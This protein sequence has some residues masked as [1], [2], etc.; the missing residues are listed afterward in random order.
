MLCSLVASAS[1]DGEKS[2]LLSRFAQWREQ[3]MMKGV[4]TNYI[5][6]PT[7]AWM[8]RTNALASNINIDEQ[9][10]GD[11]SFDRLFYNINT[12]LCWKSNL[13]LSYRGLELGYGIDFSKR[14]N[15]DIKLSMYSKGFGGEIH[16]QT[17]N[18]IQGT[19]QLD[20]TGGET[21]FYDDIPMEVSRIVVNG[22][23]VFNKK[24]FSYPAAITKSFI[25]K[26]SAGSAIAGISLLYYDMTIGDC[27]AS[28]VYD[29]AQRI[30]TFVGSAGAGYAYNFVPRNTSWLFH[31]SALPM[32]SFPISKKAYNDLSM[33][34]SHN[35]KPSEHV[36]MPSVVARTS[37]SYSI[38]DRIVLGANCIYNHFWSNPSGDMLLSTY[39]ITSQTFIAFRF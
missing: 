13:S 3:S 35:I 22:Y 30:K 5:C 26:K 6:L 16:Y 8:V 32:L 37:V 31:I 36:I 1:G 7:K 15:R 21:T 19:A 10:V 2:S 11:P 12:G 28:A 24:T 9:I 38:H 33:I 25:Q 14:Y 29:K 20:L 18:G 4:D 17:Y 34:A 27:E 39:S 23:Y